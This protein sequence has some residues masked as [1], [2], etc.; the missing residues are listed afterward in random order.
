MF[1]ISL[2]IL[3]DKFVFLIRVFKIKTIGA[4]LSQ[5]HTSNIA[6]I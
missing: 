2:N 5:S 1:L 6:K 4:M 3:T